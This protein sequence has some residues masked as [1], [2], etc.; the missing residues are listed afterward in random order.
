[1]S[2]RLEPESM[3]TMPGIGVQL[4]RNAHQPEAE[5]LM[6]TLG[7]RAGRGWSPA[8]LRPP[9]RQT[10][11]I[12]PRQVKKKILTEQS[13]VFPF[14]LQWLPLVGEDEYFD[15]NAW[16][17]LSPLRARRKLAGP[18]VRSRLAAGKW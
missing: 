3:L 9:G 8:A 16:Q 1:M 2:D 6:V 18:S 11:A 12:P 14:W 15:I 7:G 5:H 4:G 10:R 13:S 17:G